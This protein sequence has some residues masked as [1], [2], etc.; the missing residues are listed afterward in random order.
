MLCVDDYI[1]NH[2]NSATRPLAIQISTELSD[3]LVELDKEGLLRKKL[4]GTIEEQRQIIVEAQWNNDKILA[5]L[6]KFYD[7]YFKL[8]KREKYLEF[9]K[10]NDFTDIDL[11]HLLHSQMIFAFLSNME[12]FKN[13]LNLILKDSSSDY[14][15]GRL[16]RENGI[17]TK[18]ARVQCALVSKRLDIE[19]RN[20]FSHYTFIEKGEIIHYYSYRRDKES[21]SIKL[22]EGKIESPTLLEKTLEVS[23][24][25]A[26]LGCLIADKYGPNKLA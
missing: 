17:L 6:N 5:A 20:A 2:V 16:F 11:M 19:L 24:M 23:L 12:A 9:M 26:I 21:K 8:D 14:T 22:I 7:F 25:K 1:L 13:L 3:L 4:S 15:L 18:N 10:N